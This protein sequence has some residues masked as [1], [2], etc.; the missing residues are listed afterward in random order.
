MGKRLFNFLYN[1]VGLLASTISVCVLILLLI[2]QET[3]EYSQKTTFLLSNGTLLAACLLLLASCT[4]VYSLFRNQTD[5]FFAGLPPK[6]IVILSSLL[7]FIQAYIFY[8]M[9]FV[10]G[11]DVYLVN[12]SALYVASGGELGQLYGEYFSKFPNNLIMTWVLSVAYKV[13]LGVGAKDMAQC[14]YVVIL[15]QSA[16]SCLAGYCLFKIISEETKVTYGYFAWLLF[17]IHIALNPWITIPY[18]DAMPL[19]IPIVILRIYQLTQNEK[20]SII[21]WGSIGFAAFWG[22][23]IKPQCIIVLIAII[24]VELLAIIPNVTAKDILKKLRNFTVAIC[25]GILTLALCNEVIIPSMNVSLDPDSEIGIPHFLMMGL[26]TE[27]DGVFYS[28]DMDYSTSFSTVEERKE[29]NLRMVKHRL[30]E[31][32][33]SGLTKHLAKKT[34]VNFGDGTY[35]WSREGNF[36]NT[37]LEKRNDT[38]SP[39]LKNLY[40]EGGTYYIYFATLQHFLWMGILFCFSGIGIY[41][42]VEKAKG[43]T[44]CVAT[45]A[46]IG[47]ILF[48]TMFEARARYFFVY[49][50]IFI[51]TALMGWIGICKVFKRVYHYLIKS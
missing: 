31:M 43:S 5:S 30:R 19:C 15:L 24:I 48:Q 47:I 51:L 18:T 33:F 11:W 34:L 27:T 28:A 38:I 17:A 44:V 6:T 3:T 42:Y 29:G 16:L 39:F 25:A 23:K 49:S 26:N 50:P 35:A 20:L 8:N 21:K 46:T 9:Y 40:Y 4:A 22:F 10:T 12:N 45:L 1:C 13:G 41:H 36:Y 7:F 14:I 2:F 37:F 32:G